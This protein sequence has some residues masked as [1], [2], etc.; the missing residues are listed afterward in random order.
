M[1][2]TGSFHL[3]MC[4]FIATDMALYQYF[5]MKSN[6]TLPDKKGQ[7]SKVVPSSYIRTANKEVSQL[8]TT[9]SLGKMTRGPLKILAEQILPSML[10]NIGL[11]QPFSIS[12]STHSFW[13]PKLSRK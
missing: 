4:C 6:S 9:A 13:A 10:Q 1:I 12:P 2:I 7:L 11:L 8:T 5:K 3:C